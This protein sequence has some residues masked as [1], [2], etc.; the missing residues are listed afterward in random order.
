VDE[1]HV[2]VH[3][4]KGDDSHEAIRKKCDIR[5]DAGGLAARQTPVELICVDD[6]RDTGQWEFTFDAGRPDWW[7]EAHMADARRQ[8][9]V[10]ADADWDGDVLNYVGGL[11]LRGLTSLPASAKLSAGG[12]LDLGGLTSLPASAKLSA[13]GDLYLGGLTSLPAS[14]KLSAGGYLYLGGLTSLPAS[15]K[16]SAGGD[17]DLRGLTSL[18]AKHSVTARRVMLRAKTLTGVMPQSGRGD[19]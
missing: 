16:L 10:A 13:G 9:T 8:L 5:D 1:A 18:P 3:T 17:L 11:D 6:L 14:A 2:R 12:Y 7:T 15:A 4:L 19:V